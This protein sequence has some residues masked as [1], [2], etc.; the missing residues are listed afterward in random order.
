MAVLI[1]EN[2]QVNQNTKHIVV[3]GGCGYIGSHIVKALH[4]QGGYTITVVDWVKQKHTLKYADHFIWS[5]F[6]SEPTYDYLKL[7][8]ADAIV[9]CAGY[10]IVGESVQDPASYYVNNVAKT[11]NFLNKLRC[12]DTLPAIVFS[13]SAAV[14]GNP[15]Q[16]PIAEDSPIQPVSP[17]GHSKAM[18]EQM[19]TD[20]DRA[21]GLKS[22]CLRYF[23]ACGADPFGAELGQAPGATHIIAR[24][25]E[26]QLKQ[27]TFTL[28]GTDFNTADGTCVR[29]YIHVWDLATAHVKAIEYLLNHRTSIKLNLGTNIGVSN[30]EVIR[31]VNAIAGAVDVVESTRRAGDPDILVADA[32]LAH[33]L[34]NWQPQYSTL[35][36]IVD[37]AWKWYNKHE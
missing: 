2:I 12:F 19:L 24:L 18:T 35:P 10:L 22:A 16:L 21:Y 14:Y 7:Y 28:N 25:L 34:L 1:I 11:A 27:A 15:N 30:R 32:T 26:A 3:T 4:Q 36:T 31:H 37:T 33:D 23:N 13:S 6:D 9:H 17:Y 29:D 8:P 5:D 20:F